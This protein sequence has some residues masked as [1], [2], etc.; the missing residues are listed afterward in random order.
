MF[1]KTTRK[2]WEK[3]RR[4]FRK[5]VSVKAQKRIVLSTRRRTLLLLCLE[6]MKVNKTKNEWKRRANKAANQERLWWLAK[7]A[8]HGWVSTRGL[9]RNKNTLRKMIDNDRQMLYTKR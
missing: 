5:V 7:K 3:W 1:G 4:A 9:L 6:T 2:Y 8:L